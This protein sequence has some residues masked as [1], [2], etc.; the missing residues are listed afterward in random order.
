M[1]ASFLS[2]GIRFPRVSRFSFEVGGALCNHYHIIAAPCF[3]AQSLSDVKGGLLIMRELR[4]CEVLR[5]VQ[6]WGS[7]LSELRCCGMLREKQ[8]G[9][10]L[11]CQGLGALKR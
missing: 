5:E 2:M 8:Q 11:A 6:R 3:L 1:I 9:G 10:L 7:G 4:C